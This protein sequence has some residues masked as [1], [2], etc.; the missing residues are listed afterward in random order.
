MNKAVTP[1]QL[2]LVQ[3]DPAPV[4]PEVNLPDKPDVKPWATL[5]DSDRFDWASD[6]SVVLREQRAVA[7]Y[8]NKEGELV[9]RQRSWPDD[10]G[11][12]FVAPENVTEFLEGV[13]KRARE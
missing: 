5:S 11:F 1:E 13:A 6:D 9:I 7:A 3:D 8:Y 4:K 2:S 12:I 10:D